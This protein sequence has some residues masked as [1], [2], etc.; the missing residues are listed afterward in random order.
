MKSFSISE[1]K[2]ADFI[3]KMDKFAK[4]ASKLNIAWSYKLEST[5]ESFYMI[6]D[7]FGVLNTKVYY[8]VFEYN[9]QG[10]SPIINGFSFLAKI[11]SLGNGVNLIHSHD[12]NFD[13]TFYRTSELMCEHCKVNRFRNF[14]YL[15]KNES[16]N[17]IK[18][19][20]HNCLA[21]YIAQDN[22]EDIAQFYSDFVIS[23]ESLTG[24][25][26]ENENGID[27]DK[28]RRRVYTLDIID[29]VAYAINNVNAYGYVSAKNES[30]DKMST[31][32]SV[33]NDLF[34]TT[35]KIT[36]EDKTESKRII[37]YV[38]D[39]LS[40]KNQLTDY[41]FN[42]LKLIESGRMKLN[43]SGYIVSIIPLYNKIMG[44]SVSTKEK[45][46]SNFIG[47]E[48]QKINNVNCI[49]TFENKYENNFNGYTYLYKFDSDGNVITYFSSRDL[50]LS[51]G[52]NVII[53]SATV[54]KHDTYNGINQTVITRGKIQT[55]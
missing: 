3:A 17:S 49:V 43:H 42:I 14:Y 23:S 15:V 13:F 35:C 41:E 20:G 27:P 44:E 31:K 12:S 18:M 28:M 30:I 24:Q 47:E 37:E 34:D 50:F 29:F 55:K 51:V 7:S 9:V 10:E 48:N 21:Q 5:S 52:D 33:I 25:N 16:D 8:N 6:K 54:K 11:E 32:E 38:K 1:F 45:S 53:L 26:D 46:Q 22:A 40:R 39:I 19:L 2:N 36:D 4:R